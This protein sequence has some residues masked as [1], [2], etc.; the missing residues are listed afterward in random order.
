MKILLT[1]SLV[2]SLSFVS[3]IEK[4]AMLIDQSKVTYQIGENKKL[5]GLYTIEDQQKN[6]RI[7]GNY[8]ENKRIGDWYC[9]DAKGQTVLRYNYTTQKILT[10]DQESI[11]TVDIKVLSN[12]TEVND[13][14]T[15]AI[16]I[17]SIDQYKK[18]LIAEL[19]DQMPPKDKSEAAK[20]T[21]SI[22]ALVDKDG[23]AK[24]IATYI[25]DQVTH[26]STL[27]LKDKVFNIEWLPAKYK[28]Q[29]YSAEVKF[30]TAFKIDPSAGT[31]RFIWNY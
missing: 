20:V 22:T 5:N 13:N 14:A 12:D 16:P 9:F 24:Y 10:L 27:F 29:S 30:E 3:F 31:R 1:T 17:C 25:L 4:T 18:I 7:R 19:K 6:I 11:A 2:L 23:K 8:K 15:V 28:G 26:Q 21:A